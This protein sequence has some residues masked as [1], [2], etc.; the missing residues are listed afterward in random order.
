M[1]IRLA[2]KVD[3]DTDRGTRIGVPNLVADCQAVEAPACFLF[4]LG[5]DQ[6]GRAITRVFRPGFFQKVSRTSVVQIYG[7]RTLLNGT[8]LPAP[9]IGRRNAA[10][11]RRVRDDG[12][13]VGIHCY[14]HYRWQDHVQTM[15]L[16]AVRAEFIA[17]RAEFLRIFGHEAKTAGAAGWQSNVKSREVYDEA[18]LLYAS[19]TR[20]GAPFFP[21]VDGRVFQTLEIPS[22]LPT[23]DELMGR[24]EYPDEKIVPH[25][26]SLLR[27]D[28]PNVFTL[29]AEIEGMG[30][31]ALFQDL[32]AECQ[33]AGVEFIRMDDLA[34]ELLANRVAIPVRDQ[35]MGTIDGRTGLVATQAA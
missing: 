2:L 26:L 31:R 15:R 7:I 1:P 35:V 11:M 16:D 8:L 21:R 20:G 23:F 6:T 17:A 10:V 18:G 32:L 9:H 34:N 33:Q 27:A 12:F 5:P 19:D 4:S 24:P 22:T 30:R 28:Q 13:E 25:F 3:V 29:H 14:N